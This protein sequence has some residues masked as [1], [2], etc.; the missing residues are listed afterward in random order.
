M[1]WNRPAIPFAV[2]APGKLPELPGESSLAGLGGD[3]VLSALKPA[4]RG[5]GVILRALLMPGPVTV[6]LSPLLAGRHAYRVDV[7]ERD[8]EDLGMVTDTLV[9]DRGR[10]GSIASVRLR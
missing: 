9:L 7:A 2:K 6:H 10:F 8:L 5:E 4:D 1:A 3:G